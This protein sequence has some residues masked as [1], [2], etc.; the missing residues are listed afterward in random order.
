MAN[1]M[2]RRR[3]LLVAAGWW[4]AIALLSALLLLTSSHLNPGELVAFL[5]GVIAGALLELAAVFLSRWSF[6]REDWR[7]WFR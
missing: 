3:G 1:E 4:V 2:N 5:A 6:D 7:R